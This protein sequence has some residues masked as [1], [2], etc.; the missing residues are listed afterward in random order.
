WF[1]AILLFL[2]STVGLL[3]AFISLFRVERFLEKLL[4]TRFIPLVTITLLFLGSFGVYLG[5]FLRWNSWDIISDP[6]GLFSAIA[7][8]LIYPFDHL[9]TWGITVLLTMVFCLL[10]FSVKKLP[11]Y[12]S[13]TA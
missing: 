3:M 10:Y 13:R 8:R 6:P 5:R 9:R 12:L 11:S 1:D 4:S 2:S 7:D